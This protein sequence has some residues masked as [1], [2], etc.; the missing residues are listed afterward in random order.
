[1]ERGRRFALTEQAVVGLF[2]IQRYRFLTIQQFR[3]VTGLNR[4]NTYRQLHL[5]EQHG[6]LR[7]FGNTRL[8]GHG[9]TP[10]AYFLTRKGFELVKEE[11]DLPE[12]ILGSFK[13]IKVEAAWSPHMYHRLRT[14]DALL[15]VECAIRNRPHLTMVKT[16]LEYR[17]KKRGELFVAETTDYVSSE[18]TGENKIIPDAAFILENIETKRRALFFLE[19]DMATERIISTFKRGTKASLHYKFTQY[20]RYLQSLRYSQTYK[21]FGDF[22][23]FTLLFITL[24]ET[25]IE[26]IRRELQDL[27]LELGDYYRFT[28]FEAA[29]GDFLSTIWLSRAHSDTT[30]YSLVREEPVSTA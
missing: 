10:K 23:N 1:M 6:I 29:M 9:K 28:T 15:S 20:D 22:R 14:I 25:R 27:P 3:R 12:E 11:S 2:F 8:A 21:E 5:F 7:S 4:S 17:K 19:M 18:E 24:N 13:E 16:F 30:R 26:H